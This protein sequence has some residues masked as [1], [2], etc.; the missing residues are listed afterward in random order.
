MRVELRDGE[1]Q[2][3][4]KPP[5]PRSVV[6]SE[7]LSEDV[8]LEPQAGDKPAGLIDTEFTVEDVTLKDIPREDERVAEEKCVNDGQRQRGTVDIDFKPEDITLTG[9]EEDTKKNTNHSSAR[10]NRE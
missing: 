10:R 3:I 5:T 1:P 2:S 8:T 4:E 6:V 9:V 7:V